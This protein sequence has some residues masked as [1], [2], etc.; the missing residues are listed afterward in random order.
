MPFAL[1]DLDGR[2]HR[3]REWSG[4]NAPDDR[5]QRPRGDSAAA[6]RAL[7]RPQQRYRPLWVERRAAGWLDDT[8][9]A[10]LA[11]MADIF[12]VRDDG[13]SF[14]AGKDTPGTH[15]GAR[16]RRTR[17]R[18]RG[19]AD[20]VARRAL[21]RSRRNSAPRRGS[22]SSV[23]QRGT[24]GFTRTRCTSTASSGAATKS[25]MWI[26]RRSPTKSIDPGMLDNLVGGGIAAG[27]TVGA[28]L[29]KEAWEEAGI[30]AQL[31]RQAQPAGAV[32]ICRE[33]PDGLQRET[34][35]VHDLWLPVEFT[36]AGQDGEVVEHRIVPLA[37]A[38]RLIA[39]DDG[40]DIVTA[41][42][43]PRHPRLP[44]A[45]WRHRAR[46][47][48]VRGDRAAAAP[49]DDSLAVLHKLASRAARRACREREP[50]GGPSSGIAMSHRNMRILRTRA[51][52][53]SRATASRCRRLV[54]AAATNCLYCVIRFGWNGGRGNPAR[55]QPAGLNEVGSTATG[56]KRNVQTYTP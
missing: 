19:P 42:A 16:P 17:A 49:R 1:S 27:Q 3:V 50:D 40:P 35:F 46:R 53:V 14:V 25:P 12:D 21:R 23:P 47:G 55:R 5:R 56:G 52:R 24:S 28:A 34:I 38:A 10:R 45:P 51:G 36:P 4:Y 30:A 54:R 8:R 43:A 9:S 31:V 18:R 13:I 39:N 26:A 29:V 22:C 44:A 20:R 41:D 6:A 2:A 7:A 33:P 32:Q 15:F 11:A 48:G 37:E